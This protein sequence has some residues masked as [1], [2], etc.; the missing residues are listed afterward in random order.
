[1]QRLLDRAP[2]RWRVPV[3][4][5]AVILLGLI[6]GIAFLLPVLVWARA[7]A[8]QPRTVLL[9]VVAGVAILLVRRAGRW[10]RVVLD[11]APQPWRL[12]LL[13]VYGLAA[14]GPPV[15]VLL[16]FAGHPMP[17]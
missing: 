12:P 4:A 2:A 7:G 1:M 15:A 10:L 17:G 8:R 5:G 16:V 11:A 13:G 9:V 3:Q 14:M 6:V